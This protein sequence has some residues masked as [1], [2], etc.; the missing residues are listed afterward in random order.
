MSKIIRAPR[1]AQRQMVCAQ[2][3]AR[4]MRFRNAHPAIH[5]PRSFDGIGWPLFTSDPNQ[6]ARD[7]VRRTLSASLLTVPQSM[8]TLYE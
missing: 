8:S 7:V 1:V 6:G 2:E 3:S 4:I 5:L